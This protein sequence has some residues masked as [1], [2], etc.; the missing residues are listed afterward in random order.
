MQYTDTMDFIRDSLVPIHG[1]TVA[2]YSG[3]GGEVYD[4]DEGW[5]TV[6]KERVKREFSTDEGYVDILVCTD[7]ASE[8][9]NLQECGAHGGRV[10]F[11]SEPAS[12]VDLGAGGFADSGIADT[13]HVAT[14]FTTESIDDGR[15]L[16]VSSAVCIR[17][18]SSRGIN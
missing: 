1:E 7:S 18:C 14:V 11:Q 12:E 3:R 13:E 10:R 2:T 6:G 8:G 17:F 16:S 9:L 4:T 15:A 5:R